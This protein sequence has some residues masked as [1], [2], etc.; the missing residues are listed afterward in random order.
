MIDHEIKV[1]AGS[2]PPHESP[3][4]FSNAKMEELRTQVE[5]LLEQDWIWPSSS[6]YRAPILFIP[7]KN[8]QLRMCID[9][10]V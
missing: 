10:R 6:P 3:C 4:R 8:G 5:T 9:F 2:K 7:E 1:V